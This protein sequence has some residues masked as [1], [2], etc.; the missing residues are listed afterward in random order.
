MEARSAGSVGGGGLFLLA[1]FNVVFR[2]ADQV[3]G[4]DQ[5]YLLRLFFR[6]LDRPPVAQHPPDHPEGS[7]SNRCRA[8]NER[9]AVFGIISDLEK[10][11]YLFVFR[12]A[13]DDRDIEITQTQLLRF[14][15]FFG[16]AVL[17]GLSK[18]DDYFHSIIFELGQMFQAGLATGAKLFVDLQEIPDLWDFLR[19]GLRWEQAGQRNNQENE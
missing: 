10:L 17:A 1:L 6:L 7:D 19:R 8:M 14:R 18:I 11:V 12:L 5:A 15:L 4:I 9:G 16:G 2:K 3:W 13:V